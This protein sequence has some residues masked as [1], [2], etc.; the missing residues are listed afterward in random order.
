M[1]RVRK[2]N[3]NLGAQKGLPCWKGAGKVF[4]QA[5]DIKQIYW[6]LRRGNSLKLRNISLLGLPMCKYIIHKVPNC[7][8]IEF[9]ICCLPQNG[10]HWLTYAGNVFAN[11]QQFQN[12][13]QA[14]RGKAC[15]TVWVYLLAIKSKG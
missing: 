5:S 10:G 4:I 6:R 8:I 12:L 13:S 7:A 9:L 15:A 3:Q 14:Q 2:Q 1:C 11:L